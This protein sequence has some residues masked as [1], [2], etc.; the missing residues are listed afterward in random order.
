[1]QHILG[2]PEDFAESSYSLANCNAC[3]SVPQDFQSAAVWKTQHFLLKLNTF[4][5]LSRS[6]ASEADTLGYCFLVWDLVELDTAACKSLNG[7]W[8]QM[9]LFVTKVLA[10]E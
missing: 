9:G 1:M 7:T 5:E 2:T 10:K 8:R 4:G 3:I 6:T